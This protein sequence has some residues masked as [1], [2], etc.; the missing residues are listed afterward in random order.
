MITFVYGTFGSGKTHSVIESIKKDVVCGYH[1]FLIVPEQEAVQAERTTLISL[2]NSA[3]LNLEVLNFSRLYN[4]V[5]REY[6]GLSYRYITKPIRN[7][8]MWQNMRELS[9]LLEEYHMSSD[10][11]TSVCDIMLSSI[12]ECKAC[13]ITPDMLENAA[14]K[15]NPDDPLGRRLRDLALIYAS[16]DRLVAQNYSDSADDIARLYDVL[17]KEKF[18]KGTS[19][20]I[21]SFTSFT[22]AEHRVI[23]KIFAQADNVTVTVPLSHPECNDISVASI[24][25]SLKRLKKN[26]DLHGG[27]REVILHGNR[28]AVSKTLAYVSENLWKLDVSEKEGRVFNDGGIHIEICD[29]PYAEAEAVANHTLE[30]LR[31]GERCRDIL[32]LMRSPEKYK[33][34]IEPAFEKNGIPYFFSEKTDLSS[35]PP[36]KLL[37]SALR[38]KQYNWQKND[39]ISHIKTGLYSFSERSADLFEEYL[40]TWNIHG[41]SFTDVDAWTMNPDGYVEQ[42]S[43]RGRGI[44]TAANEVRR[45]L[46]DTLERFFILLDA[47]DTVADMCRAVYSYFCD[48]SL[49]EKLSELAAAEAARNN[50][51]IASELGAIYG[52]MLNALADIATALPDEE[53]SCDEFALILKTVFNG[54]EIGTIPTSVDEVMIGSAATARAANPKYTF[55]LGLCDGE[56]PATISDSGVFS[57]AD[58]GELSSLGIE[59]SS[60]ADTRSSD[61]LMYAQKAFST[62]SH[63]LY[64]TTS[65]AEFGGKARNPSMPYNRVLALLND[66]YVPHRF[67][68]NDLKYLVGAPK[69]AA[70]HLRTL[71]GT[72]WGGALGEALCDYFPETKEL[73]ARSLSASDCTVSPEAVELSLGSRVARFSSTRFEKYV[74]CPFSYYC[75]YVLKLREKVNSDFLASDMGTFIHAIL[76]HVIYFATTPKEDGE[77]P[78]DAEITSMTEAEVLNYIERNCP[79]ELKR[80]K[81]LSHIYDRLKKLA[82]LMV[83]NIVD[84]F[85]HSDFHPEYFELSID[86]KDGS[87]PPMEFVLDDG[88]KVSF[89]GKIDRVDVLRKDGKAYVR[90]V[91]YKTGSKVFSL[92]DVEHGI[93]TQMLLYLFMLCK[94]PGEQLSSELGID[95]GDAPIP[96]GI[97]YLS[98]N[99]P[100]IQS[101]RFVDSDSLVGEAQESLKRSGLLLDDVD[102]LSAMNHEL[103]RKFLAGIYQKKDGTLTGNALTSA[104]KFEELYCQISD[105]VKKIATELRQ[106]KAGAIPLIYDKNDPCEYCKMKP[107]CRREDT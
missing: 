98:A 6:G 4:R 40:E 23:E 83:R 76:E 11:D 88:Y 72:P 32:V 78:S 100:M 28:R 9:P 61:E 85:S 55:V 16:Y 15:L 107:I 26:A 75:T 43:E 93:N 105:T 42:M 59:L 81:K 84:E 80:S 2:P 69:S 14:K 97:M 77:L 29:T 82:L 12:G 66:D 17:Q 50:I 73:S 104:E 64:L 67:S 86:G 13:G 24:R 57:S 51:K 44:L 70:I 1:T 52:V 31:R 49:E 90:V 38:I 101:E 33:G 47:S 39:I 54:T 35:L 71:E 58:R 18:F 48:I 94:S 96:S 102:I 103:S 46:M 63:R 79:R 8:L 53:V 99:I 20:Y 3:Q 37:F 25:E 19:V 21:D 7:L 65:S 87:L 106:G 41:S 68:G 10:K 36:V 27:Y 89:V 62:P 92:D 22:A 5:C 45:D 95:I 30:L 56:F 60:N 74:Q 34:I 91:D